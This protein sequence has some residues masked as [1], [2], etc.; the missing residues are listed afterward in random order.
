MKRIQHGRQTRRILLSGTTARARRG[1][2]M[3]GLLGLGVVPALFTGGSAAATA[4]VGQ[5]FNVTASDLSHILRQI[6]I[7]EAHVATLPAVLAGPDGQLVDDPSTAA[8]EAAD[9]GGMC[10]GLVGPGPDQI[11]TPLVADGLRTVDGSCNNLIHGQEKFGAEG[12]L[13]PRL[14]SAV[15]K[16]A[17]NVPPGFGPPGGPPVPTSYTQTSGLVFDSQPRLISNLIVDQT[18]TNPSA[19]SAAGHPVRTQGNAGVFSCVA[20]NEVQTLSGTPTGDFQLE[21]EGMTTT[22]LS[23]TA[24]AADVRAALVAL[25]NVGPADV[26]VSGG[27]LPAAITIKFVGGL[28]AKNVAQLIDPA[29][30]GLVVDTATQGDSGDAG[31]VPEHETLFI[32]NVTTDVGLSPPFNSMF[33]IFGQFFDHGVDQT[34]KGGS[35]TVFVP[36][37][38]DDPL[39][40]GPDHILNDDPDTEADEALDNLPANQRFMVL[41][42]AT[43]QPGPDHILGTADDIRDATNTDSPFVD[44][45]QTYTSHASHQV[46]LREYVLTGAVPDQRPVATGKL[47]HSADGGMGTWALVKQQAAEKLGLKLRDQDALDIPMVAADLYGNFIKGPHG[48]PQYVTVVDGQEV[49]VEGNLANPVE[50][51]VGV[52]HFNIPFLTDIA[53]SAVPTPGLLPDSNITAG[54]QLDVTIPAGSYDNELL[55]LHFIAGD[56]RVN[57][58]IALTAVHQIFHSEHD[59]LVDDMKH[60]L[61][62]TGDVNVLNQWLV[63][64]LAAVPTTQ[65]AIDALIDDLAAWRGERLFQAA[66]FVTEMEYQHLVFEEFAR[67]VQPLI[68]PFAGFAFTQTNINPAVKAE[69]AHAVYRFGHSMLTETIARRNENTPANQDD[70]DIKLLDGFLN[71][72]SYTDGGAAGV[73]SS[74][75]AAGSIFMGMSDQTGNEIDEFVTDT[76]RNNLLGL[77]L[78]LPTINMTRARSEGIP[79][80]NEL[81]RQIYASTND[82]QLKP[83][84]NWIDFGLNL[85]HP[86][87]LINFVAAYGRHPSIA[88]VTEI[89]AKRE[90]A[91]VIVDPSATDTPPADAGEFLN[92]IGAWAS[93]ETGLNEVDLWVGGLAERTNLFGGLLG[94]TFN[95]VFESQLTDLQNSDRLYYLGRTPGMNLRAQLEGNSFAELVMRNTT[96]HS[97]KADAFGTADCKFELTNLPPADAPFTTNILADDPTSECDEHALLIRMADGTIAYRT[98]NTVDPAGINGQSVY[99]GTAGVDRIRGGVDNDTFLGN[100]GNDIIEGRDG[101]DVALG[102]EGNDRITDDAGDD[103]LKGGPGNDAIEAGPGLDIIMGGTGKD[104]MNGGANIN[105]IFAGDGDDF[106]ILGQGEDA[107]QGDGGDDW[108]EGGDQPDLLQGDSGGLF[109]DDRNQP[110]ND[111]FIGQAGDDDYDAEGGDDIMVTGPGI[112]KSA[113]A[114]GYDWSTGFSDPLPQVADLALK[115]LPADN[116]VAVDVRDRFNETE[117]LSGG[118]LNDNLKGDS[119]VPADAGAGA[120]VLGC[121]ALDQHSLDRIAGLDALV[122]PLTTPSGPIITNSQTNNCPLEGDVWGEG[123]ILLGGGGSDVLEG[124]GANDIIDGDKY[125]TVRLSVRNHALP[126][127]EI[128]S[129]DLMESRYL[130]DANGALTGPTL[131]DAVMAGTVDPGDIVAV[132]E[133]LPTSPGTAVDTAVFS[134]V[135]ANYTITPNADDSTTVSH[136]AGAGADGTDILWNIERLQFADGVIDLTGSVVPGNTAATGAPAIAGTPTAGSALTVTNGTIADADGIASVSFV[137]QA[138]VTPGNFAQ[139]GTGATFTPGPSQVGQRLRVVAAVLDNQSASTSL[140]SDLTAPVAAAPIVAGNSLPTGTPIVTDAVVGGALAGRPRVNDPLGTDTLGIVDVDG[141]VG[142]TFFFQWQQSTNGTTWTDIAGATGRT[143]TPTVVQLGDLLRVR[144]AFTDQGGSLETLDSAPTRDVRPA[145]GRGGR[146]PVLVLNA[147]AV[148]R[149]VTVSLVARRG[150]PVSFTAPASTTVVRVM[151]FRVGSKRPLATQFIRVKLGKT[152][153]KLRTAAMRRALHLRGRYRIEVT[154]GRSRAAFGK[155][156]VRLLTVRR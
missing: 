98:T 102:G 11:A 64:P 21:F 59:R 51:P 93:T 29:V 28:K 42:R 123:N 144:V 30:T 134:D 5:G 43:N 50:P 126:A 44:Q 128:G 46:Y 57:E 33:T 20:R 66:R 109:F 137:W 94:S 27:P 135:L 89:A 106:L 105:E 117:A 48:L 10:D 23:P 127:V 130:R 63:T 107:G 77:P 101:A 148:P 16:N 19:V 17:D 152:S 2:A 14:T 132:R 136:L 73:L 1:L 32:P 18:S 34:V 139:V 31:C 110:G 104:F 68:N 119:I 58:N 133:I 52:K 114:A 95:Y 112:E 40:A 54:K 87:S 155:A 45:S 24:T 82:S 15:F 9:N 39:I 4:P 62:G 8:N 125:L 146:P 81:R 140:P 86:E 145:R 65:V 88:N 37:Q 25:D 150:L 84:T 75:Q 80:L 118:P 141:L 70:N 91:R 12:Q 38:D 85:K 92:S 47:I 115:I 26:S 74:Q 111:V 142:V 76:L 90:A 156:T 67:K 3:T 78:D 97:L 41:S 55:D 151:V 121:D 6:K 154:P 79:P 116:I 99:N 131:Q 7:A 36:L 72:A 147:L 138:E 96:A 113:G 108:M 124:R 71:P 13:F 149:T 56:G 122:P 129:A 22:S 60:T 153:V 69:F 53:H 49:L 35:G 83:Y 120:G 143:F 103:V 100:E 61:I